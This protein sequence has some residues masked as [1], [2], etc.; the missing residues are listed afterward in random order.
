MEFRD[1]KR[2]YLALKPQI[3]QAVSDIMAAGTFIAG[4]PV[5]SFEN[6][7]A[8]KTNRTHCI[9]CANGTDAL[10]LIL[11]AWDI[12][13]GDAV[14]VPDFTFFATAEPVSLL[15]AV[16]IF[17]DVHRD[18]FNINAASLDEAIASVKK[19][20]KLRPRAVIAVDL[21]GQTADYDAINEI[22]TKH[23]LLLFED[24][25]Q[26]FG[27][28]YKG[29]PACSFGDAAFTSFFPAKPLGCYGDGGAIFTN[30][31]DKASLIRSL[32]V[33]GKGTE[34]Y[35]N[36][37]IGRNSRLDTIQ[38][39]VLQ[40]KLDAFESYEIADINKAAEAYTARIKK[41]GIPIN[42]PTVPSDM[43]SSWAQYTVRFPSEEMRT[44]AMNNLSAK[45]IP[46]MIYYPKPMH[47][48]TAFANILNEQPGNCIV[49]EELS[50]TALSLP[51]HPYITEEEI[52]TVCDALIGGF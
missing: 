39:A 29:K 27:A 45:G 42:T 24:T 32:A 2:Q 49:S 43:I 48:Q 3:D 35:D 23:D 38:A 36:I 16:P 14:F 34:K 33:H 40:V 50:K 20:G 41:S 1:L 21:F 47:Q 15:G 37:R 30:D 18:T 52:G 7:L 31:P 11:R 46:S 5:R 25:A 6:R 26:G 13:A 10:E 12:G 44:K 28:M 51:L 9:S 17:V 4:E 8:A 22:V 19:A